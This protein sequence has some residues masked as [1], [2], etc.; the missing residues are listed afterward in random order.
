MQLLLELGADAGLKNSYG[1]TAQ[2]AAG[3]NRRDGCRECS[4]LCRAWAERQ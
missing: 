1:E 4:E 3:A 2:Q